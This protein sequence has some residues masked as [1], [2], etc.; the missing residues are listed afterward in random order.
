MQEKRAVIIDEE[1][2]VLENDQIS[3][4]VTVR[5]GQMAPV[6]FHRATPSPVQ[7]YYVSPWQGT[8]LKTGT[9]VLDMLRGDFFCMPFGGGAPYHG[10]EYPVHGESAGSTWS[11]QETGR[12]GN[13]TRLRLGLETRVRPGK[14][15]KRLALVDGHNVVY[16]RHDLEGYKGRMSLSHHATIAVPEAPGS[17]RL[18]TA[19]TRLAKVVP[20]ET[21][22]NSGNEYYFLDA[23]KRF[24]RLDH[25]PTI[26]KH[27]PWAD[28]STHPLPYG[29][30][31][32]VCVYPKLAAF[33]AWTAVAAPSQG[34]LWF[35]LRDARLLPQTTF[36]M[37]N[38][39]RHAA[40]WSG[41]NR[42]LGVEDGCAYYTSGLAES[43]RRNELNAETIPTTIN[44]SP[45]RPTQ[46]R[47]IQG[48]VKIPPGFDRA[49]SLAFE[50]G[51]VT[52][53][54][55]SGKKARAAVSW[56]FLETGEL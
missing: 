14:I 26:W 43:A 3:L 16:I 11:F 34:W 7:P 33:P 2:W 45:D 4:A 37:S 40:P 17:L 10:E 39:G 6:T 24:N 52:F 31:D 54:S 15:T 42:C 56:D 46:I 21:Y 51:E 44:L 27:A 36:W 19:P 30:M 55:F 18:S 41:R 35:A 13:V 38:G 5:G 25:V 32:L 12:T 29:F 23:G 50:K 9:P 49:K 20:R 8:G 48:V 47:H 22:A 1:S 53:T 28:L